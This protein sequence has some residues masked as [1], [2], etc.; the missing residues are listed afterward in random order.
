ME[1]RP[2]C[3][4]RSPEF[5]LLVMAIVLSLAMTVSGVLAIAARRHV[6]KQQQTVTKLML[7]H[8]AVV[9]T[10][11][12]GGIKRVEATVTRIERRLEELEVYVGDDPK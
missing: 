2:D 4:K 5:W 8:N 3:W 10:A 7:D 9:D 1:S 11:V 6:T 12:V